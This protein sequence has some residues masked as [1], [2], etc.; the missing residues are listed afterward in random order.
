[1][2]RI[3]RGL[4]LVMLCRGSLGKTGGCLEEALKLR[5]RHVDTLEA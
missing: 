1:M 4:W 3:S 2:A 5:R